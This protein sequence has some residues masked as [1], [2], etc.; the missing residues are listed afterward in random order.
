MSS[1]DRPT[2]PA[3]Y[4]ISPESLEDRDYYHDPVEVDAYMDEL[5][6]KLKRAVDALADLVGLARAAMREA[7]VYYDI[8]GE[9]ADAI[10]I[11][12]EYKETPDGP[13]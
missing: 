5:E 12:A 4:I 8:D 2:R 11:I 9:L 3:M 6:V 7:D 10:A 1:T 13:N